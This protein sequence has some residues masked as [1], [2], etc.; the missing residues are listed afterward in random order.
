MSSDT[1][2][3]FN[4]IAKDKASA[5]LARFQERV[6]TA[7]PAIGAGVAAG[8]A[9]G[10][11]SEL[12]VSAA[13]DRL[14]AQLGVGPAEAA[15]LAEVSASVYTQ[16][17]GDSTTTVNNAIR[18]V[19]QSIG[20]TSEAEGGLEGVTIKALALADV[21]EQDVGQVTT[22]VGQMLSTGLADNADQAFDLITAGMEAG[23]NRAGDFLDTLIGG[24]DNLKTFGFDGATATGLIVQ[25]LD[26]GAE[27][28]DSVVG[29]FEELVGNVAAGGDDLA[30]IFTDLGLNAAEV[31][32]GLTSGG[33]EAN[34]ALDQLLD[35][36]RGVEDGTERAALM[37]SLFGEEGAA[38]QNTLMAIDP[39]SAVQ[40]LGQIEG[41]AGEMAETLGDNPAAAL[42]SFKRQALMQLASIAGGIA[43]WA[44]NN[45]GIVRPL[46]VVLGVV[47]A[48]ILLVKAGTMAWAAAQT[49]ATVATTVWQG[50]Q[51]LLNAALWAS[52]VTWIIAGIIALIAIVVLIA[53]QTTWFQDIWRVA[54]DWIKDAAAGVWN[55]ITGHWPLLLGI[56]TGPIGLAV[57]L[58]TD[59][60]DRVVGFVRSLPGRISSAA[61]GMW[62][63]IEDGFRS[64]V[65]GIISGWNSLS[66]TVGGGSFM[67]VGVP[68]FTLDTPNIP[69]LATGGIITRA[70]AAIVGERGPELLSM[71]R[72]AAVNPLP[73]GGGRGGGG[74]IYQINLN[75]DGRTLARLLIDPMRG[76][77]RH[78]S[79]GNVQAALG[80]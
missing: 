15:E 70:G 67:G 9:A 24:A 18:G 73:R 39:S 66:F 55:W 23:A 56:L 22:A 38:M 3:I 40:A 43:S 42:E 62:N 75:V 32:A 8:L 61:S 60:F 54:W 14:A 11:M 57:G 51:W 31:T 64:A 28:A 47:A 49:I 77:I 74:G 4:I 35:A 12:D 27:S 7:A 5:A 26:A 65:N 80:Q 44:M 79:G 2:L 33:P 16:A 76:E 1:S 52:P 53:T 21:L 10:L 69:M 41:A 20:D 78:I 46:A 58:I 71:P 72:G 29:L 50:A 48:T 34:A 25:G 13:N 68:S 36:L 37:A 17:W 30:Q 45:Q 63:G 59:N 6:D 19:Y